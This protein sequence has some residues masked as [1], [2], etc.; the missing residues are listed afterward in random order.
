APMGCDARRR[1]TEGL[2]A[3]LARYRRIVELSTSGRLDGGDVL[4]VG[5]TLY[6]GLSGRT[7]AQ[8]CELLRLAAEPHGYR[9]VPVTTRSCLHLKSACTWLGGDV[10]LA[11]RSWVDTRA[12]AGMNVIDTSE[13]EPFAANALRIGDT[14]VYP[15]GFP[16]TQE[17]LQRQGF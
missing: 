4:R 11:N 17:T 9:V 5:A 6:I 10:L 8:G 14:V 1:E 7:N 13:E 3:V 15:A 16:R 12:L 2:A